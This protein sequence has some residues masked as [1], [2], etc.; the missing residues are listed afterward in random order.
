MAQVPRR[1]RPEDR[2]AFL[3]EIQS[4]V[5]KQFEPRRRMPYSYSMRCVFCGAPDIF[6]IN[7]VELTWH[8]YECERMGTIEHFKRMMGS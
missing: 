8:C 3:Q 4:E 2:I 5:M 1:S 6:H 7:V